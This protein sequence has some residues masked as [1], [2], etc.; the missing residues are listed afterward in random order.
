[1]NN[2]R[3]YWY[4]DGDVSY[5]FGY[6][7]SYTTF[8]YDN[9]EIDRET[10][11]PN[12]SFTVSTDVT[13]TGEV[14]GDEIVQVYV[15]TPDSPASLERPIKRLKGFKRVTI[16]AGQTKTVSIEIDG[17]DLWFW[18]AENEQITFDQGTYVFE[19]GPSSRSIHG[20]VEAEMHGKYKPVLKTVVA[21]AEN[22]VMNP[23][24]ST[25]SSVT[26]SLSNDRFIN[27]SEADVK[28]KSNNPQVAT[29]NKS[30]KVSTHN[31][32]VASI[33]ASVR[34]DGNTVSDSYVI[35]VMPDLS[36]KSITVNGS[37]ITGFSAGTKAY[38]YLLK[39]DAKVPQVQA[40]AAD[41]KTEVE[42]EQAGG[43]PGT[44][45]INFVDHNTNQKNTYYVN[46]DV[47]SF[48]DE[49]NGTLGSQWNWIRENESNHSLSA[50]SGALTITSEP[51]DVS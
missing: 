50:T 33:T 25:P 6:G 26:A 34:Y 37:K 11:T 41:A 20:E 43:I 1:E 12:G 45:V 2:G 46:F 38:S 44:A 10:I 8:E 19:I 23:G 28:F 18:D 24:K 47:K 51:G 27:L 4:Y 36:P 35:K 3:T 17:S 30:G 40:T 13:N 7:L 15:K 21:E 32:G 22:L 42:V 9:F 5:E 14:D 29:V 16:P 49:F 31:P 39:K 48:S